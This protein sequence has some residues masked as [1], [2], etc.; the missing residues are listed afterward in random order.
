MTN[1]EKIKSMNSEE[2]AD[3]ID[4]IS[5]CGETA[6]KDCILSPEDCGSV[7]NIEEWLMKEVK[8]DKRTIL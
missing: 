3:F 2:M 1:L 4:I 8:N 5:R 7:K 6:C